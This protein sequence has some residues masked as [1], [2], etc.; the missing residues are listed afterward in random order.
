MFLDNI[1]VL[2]CSV[3]YYEL[4]SL[5]GF[6]FYYYVSFIVLFIKMN[7]CLFKINMFYFVILLNIRVILIFGVRC[8]LL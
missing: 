3:L 2:L 6:F 7:R 1:F 4:Y 8:V 5:L